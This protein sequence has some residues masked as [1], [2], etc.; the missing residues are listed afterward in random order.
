MSM[1][2][3]VKWFSTASAAILVEVLPDA[4]R[5]DNPPATTRPE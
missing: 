5:E 1:A 3:I 2:E 4:H